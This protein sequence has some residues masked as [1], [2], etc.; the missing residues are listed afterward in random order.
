MQVRPRTR[1]QQPER[2]SKSLFDAYREVVQSKEPQLDQLTIVWTEVRK[3]IANKEHSLETHLKL[4]TMLGRLQCLRV[5]WQATVSMSDDKFDKM[6]ARYRKMQYE[7]PADELVDITDLRT[8]L[9]AGFKQPGLF[10]RTDLQWYDATLKRR[11]EQLRN[12]LWREITKPQRMQQMGTI[13]QQ[14]EAEANTIKATAATATIPLQQKIE[15]LRASIK[16]LEQQLA[17][18]PAA[19]E[20]TATLKAS[21]KT[22][23]GYVG[24]L[25]AATSKA[26]ALVQPV[27]DRIDKHVWSEVEHDTVGQLKDEVEVMSLVGDAQKT[28]RNMMTTVERTST[29]AI[30]KSVTVTDEEHLGQ[31]AALQEQ[32]EQVVGRIANRLES[33]TEKLAKTEQ[34]SERLQNQATGLVN[35]LQSVKAAKEV[36]QTQHDAERKQ[37]VEQIQSLQGDIA[38]AQR[39]REVLERE[40]L[41]L[42]KRIANLELQ[43]GQDQQ[44][45]TEQVAQITQLRQLVQETNDELLAKNKRIGEIDVALATLQSKHDNLEKTLKAATVE[46]DRKKAEHTTK[47]EQLEEEKKTAAANLAKSTE[48]VAELEK[49]LA[50]ETQTLLENQK[51]SEEQKRSIEASHLQ[52][53]EQSTAIGTLRGQLD[54]AEKELARGAEREK[55]VNASLET[56]KQKVKEI[57]QKFNAADKTAQAQATELQLKHRELTT[58]WDELKAEKAKVEAEKAKYEI[59]TQ[60]REQNAQLLGER[61]VEFTKLGKRYNELEAKWDHELTKYNDLY[62]LYNSTKS[63]SEAAT[64]DLQTA[65]DRISSQTTELDKIRRENTEIKARNTELEQ[66]V[67]RKAKEIEDLKQS[68]NNLSA[69]HS[70]VVQ[71]L[72]ALHTDNAQLI[73]NGKFIVEQLAAERIQHATAIATGNEQL[74]SLKQR[75]QQLEEKSTET[76]LQRDQEKQRASGLQGLLESRNMQVERLHTQLAQAQQTEVDL[77]NQ[78]GG[79]QQQLKDQISTGMEVGLELGRARNDLAETK[80]E[81]ETAK[82]AIFDMELEKGTLASRRSLATNLAAA[83]TELQRVNAEL[84]GIKGVKEQAERELDALRAELE[85]T[86]SQAQAAITQLQGQLCETNRQLVKAKELEKEMA[87]TAHNLKGEHE[88]LRTEMEEKHAAALLQITQLY[89]IELERTRQHTEQLNKLSQDNRNYQQQIADSARA[90]ERLQNTIRELEASLNNE[91]GHTASLQSQLETIN[92]TLRISQQQLDA[93]KQRH[94]Q[95]LQSLR[96]QHADAIQK[97]EEAFTKHAAE[98]ERQ[99]REQVRLALKELNEQNTDLKGRNALLQQARDELNAQLTDTNAKLAGAQQRSSEKDASIWTLQQQ[100]GVIT[101]NGRAWENRAKQFEQ[102]AADLEQRAAALEQK[103]ADL[104]QKR[105]NMQNS[106]RKA[107]AQIKQVTD[108]N[109]RHVALINKLAAQLAQT[110][111]LNTGDVNAIPTILR[112][113]GHIVQNKHLSVGDL[114]AMLRAVAQNPNARGPIQDLVNLLGDPKKY[115]WDIPGA[116]STLLIDRGFTQF[117]QNSVIEAVRIQSREHTLFFLE[118]WHFLHVLA[119]NVRHY[120]GTEHVLP[121]PTLLTSLVEELGRLQ[122]DKYTIEGL[123]ATWEN[124]GAITFH[125]E[126]AGAFHWDAENERKL[127]AIANGK[128]IPRDESMDEEEKR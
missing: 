79:L 50:R 75:I 80:A 14:I 31:M 59:A 32:T 4:I 128:N 7:S 104:E 44:L 100:I 120:K 92:K 18:N 78:V 65:N 127:W 1:R 9:F 71:E 105:H 112:S 68:F 8:V 11:E 87:E 93:S 76:E 84:S 5:S 61:N 33:V 58:V 98:V 70:R 114:A 99:A 48:K 24:E 117:I 121:N 37:T 125:S 74:E 54:A 101:D 89:Q 30:E 103:A 13:K 111:G 126:T 12:I 27:H 6:W 29:K 108:E 43:R 94:E 42:T 118:I 34:E 49:Q 38:V 86:K 25:H 20:V 41:E 119:G 2:K 51:L 102:S 85:S 77:R 63:L 19:E 110:I 15:E 97:N 67:N 81:L 39:R 28:M 116:A 23:T 55:A 56:E 106:G 107:V 26:N 90:S 91:R 73:T 113:M 3:Q 115:V 83:K 109:E 46:Y 88:R 52:L 16:T 95:E 60:Q 72:A 21:L 124:L 66:Q 53:T 62:S 10:Q 17:R 45:T 36:V 96:Q 40:Q 47:I 35:E 123:R 82:R 69:N 22:C 64:K 122:A 57:E